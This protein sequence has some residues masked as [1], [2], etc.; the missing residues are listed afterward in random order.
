MSSNAW[1]GSPLSSGGGRR[2]DQLTL[3]MKLQHQFYVCVLGRKV[4]L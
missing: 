3:I 2:A 1:M 4:T